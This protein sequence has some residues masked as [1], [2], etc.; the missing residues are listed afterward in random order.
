MIGLRRGARGAGGG[1]GRGRAGGEGGPAA[2]RRDHGPSRA[3]RSRTATHLVRAISALR[4][5]HARWRSGSSATAGRSRSRPGSTSAGRTTS[6]PRTGEAR[7]VADE[8]G[9]RAGP[10]GGGRCRPRLR[11]ELQVPRRPASGWWSRRCSGLD[12]GHG[13]PR[14]RATWS[15]RSTARPRPTW[16]PTA[17]WW[18]ALAAGEPAWLFVYR[19]R[20]ADVVPDARRGGEAPSEGRESSSSTTRRPSAP[21]CKMIFEYEGYECCWRRTARSG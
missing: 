13:R 1:R 8:E 17:A 6:P 19:P 14:S 2:L 15:S 3:R 20:P 9:R 12:P 7:G 4:A 11:V 5:G 21:R 16:P 10:R 18:R